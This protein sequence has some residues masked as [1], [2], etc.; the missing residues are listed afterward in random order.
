MERGEFSLDTPLAKQLPRPLEAYDAYRE[1]ASGLVRDPA[2]P[3]V[4]PRMLLSHTSGLHNFAFMEPD[5]KMH[6]HFKPGAEYRYSGEGMNLVQL[7]IEQKKGRPLDQ[8]MQEALF[9]PLG[10]KRT[11]IIYRS[12]F[13]GNVADRYGADEQFLS[14]RRSDFPRAAAGSMATSAEDLA[15]FAA[16]LFAGR[17]LKQATRQGNAD[18]G[19]S[20]AFAASI[21]AAG[22]MSRRAPRHRGGSGVRHRMGPVDADA[23][24]PPSS[25]KGTAMARRTT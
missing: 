15:R 23:F 25:R 2:W 19:D 21:R 13:A 7:A 6:L 1:T 14:A 9:S 18:A 3:T 11:G 17:I 10:M 5:K 8:L 24:G 4:T 22:A 16:G 20:P 12:D